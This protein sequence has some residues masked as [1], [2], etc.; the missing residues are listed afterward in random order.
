MRDCGASSWTCCS[1]RPSQKRPSERRRSRREELAAAPVKFGHLTIATFVAKFAD[2]RLCG[3][4]GN[5]PTACRFYAALR[6]YRS[7]P[8]PQIRITQLASEGSPPPGLRLIQ[9]KLS[10]NSNQIARGR[11]RRFESYM[12]SHAVR[13]PWVVSAQ[14]CAPRSGESAFGDLSALGQD[15]AA[16]ATRFS[17]ERPTCTRAAWICEPV[18]RINVMEKLCAQRRLLHNVN[19]VHQ[20]DSL[21]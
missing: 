13:S 16:T 3:R 9:A 4:A 21:G 11:I 18:T 2:L 12:P 1:R 7:W 17:R 5:A 10:R 8:E 6:Q 19:S 14:S 20:A 15:L